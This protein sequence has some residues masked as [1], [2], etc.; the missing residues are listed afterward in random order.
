MAKE[1]IEGCHI[2]TSV[3]PGEP[4]VLLGKDKAFTYDFV[5]DIESQQQM[6]YSS[7]VRKLIDGCFEGYN[8]TVF[9]YGQVM[10]TKHAVSSRI[11]FCLSLVFQR[12]P[13]AHELKSVLSAV[14]S[15]FFFYNCSLLAFFSTPD[16]DFS[17][18]TVKAALTSCSISLKGQYDVTAMLSAI[19]CRS[20]A[21]RANSSHTPLHRFSP[22]WKAV[23][24]NRPT[25]ICSLQR[26]ICVNIR[27]EFS[28]HKNSFK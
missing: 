28:G 17:R 20:Q 2:C 26:R 14:D 23:I 10:F 16:P 27:K 1:K 15:F 25:C 13:C 21:S 11:I 18:R 6:I 9:A 19:V 4:Q 22:H 3:T 24:I 7:C 5:F 12:S 8:A